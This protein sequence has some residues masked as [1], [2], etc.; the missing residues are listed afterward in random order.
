MTQGAEA[1]PGRSTRKGKEAW[2]LLIGGKEKGTCNLL[3]QEG[4]EIK[5]RGARRKTREW[6]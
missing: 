1:R 6:G 2:H 4:K 5:G 3:T